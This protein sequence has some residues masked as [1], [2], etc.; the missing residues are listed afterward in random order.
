MKWF[1]F[2]IVIGGLVF[3]GLKYKEEIV[4]FV[5]EMGEDKPIPGKSAGN[6]TDT[7]PKAPDPLPEEN[8]PPDPP[9]ETLDPIALKYPMPDFKPLEEYVDNWKKVPAS[10][11]PR[12][13]TL[14]AKAIF[15]IGDNVGESTRK[16]GSKNIALSIINGQLVITPHKSSILRAKV[17]IE[18]TNYKQVLNGEYE[19]YQERKRREV[20][21]QRE[22]ARAIA[23]SESRETFPQT[24]GPSTSV[25]VATASKL[26][27]TVLSEYE[28]KIGKM[29]VRDAQ[30]R[31]ALMV[32]SIEQGEVTE[33]NLNEISHWGPIR[34]EL[35]DRQPYWTGTVN[36]KTNSLFGTF[37]TEAMALIR[38]GKVDAWVYTGSLEEVP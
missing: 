31:V 20:Q 36:Y 18:D 7:T 32:Q 14:K 8:N 38:N 17:A 26:P 30:G 9:T 35:V 1:I 3:A 4:K 33:M 12:E 24:S 37:D 21:A 29:P 19:K 13:I 2:L 23:A 6:A 16:A 34:Y 25:T 10:A 11:F 15:I 27:K 5:S 28:N 22:R